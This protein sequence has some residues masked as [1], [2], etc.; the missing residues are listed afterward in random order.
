MSKEDP[1]IYTTVLS[2]DSPRELASI[3]RRVQSLYVKAWLVEQGRLSE[4]KEYHLTG[5]PR[6]E[7]ECD[8]GLKY[9]RPVLQTGTVLQ[10]VTLD[11]PSNHN[12]VLMRVVQLSLEEF[13]QNI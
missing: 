7:K 11:V 13:K 12:P 1:R 10:N 9:D 2:A 8:I 5:D 6:F 3:A 4:A